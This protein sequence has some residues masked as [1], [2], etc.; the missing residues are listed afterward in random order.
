MLKKAAIEDEIGQYIGRVIDEEVLF[1]ITELNTYAL[2]RFERTL[3][4]IIN[5][6][7]ELI[8]HSIIQKIKLQQPHYC[9][10]Q[11]KKKNIFILF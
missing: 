8:G 9:P 3:H 6:T 11:K 1:T 2:M 4:K 5:K 7:G 10:Y